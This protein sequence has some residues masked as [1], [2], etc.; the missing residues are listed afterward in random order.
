MEEQVYMEIC[1]NCPRAK[2]CHEYCEVCEEFEERLHEL[3]E[4]EE[5]NE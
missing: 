3:E 2:F 1:V 5:E 4:L